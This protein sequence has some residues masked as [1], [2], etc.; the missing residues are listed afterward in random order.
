M[1]IQERHLGLHRPSD[2][3]SS[4]GRMEK[5]GAL[6]EDNLD[7]AALLSIAETADPPDAPP[8]PIQVPS[9]SRPRIAV[10]KDD[11][12]CFYYAE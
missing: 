2:S 11:A 6:V 7:M 9:S 1:A 3:G 5:L 4:E 12:F 8:T 10:A